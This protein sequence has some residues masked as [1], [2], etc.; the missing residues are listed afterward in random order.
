MSI[1]WQSMIKK[2]KSR[3][4]NYDDPLIYRKK[5]LVDENVSITKNGFPLPAVIEISESGMCN[6]KCVFCPRSDPHYE[7]VNEFIS[8]DLIERLTS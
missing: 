1:L 3:L 5:K 4:S 7:H 6:R 8:S 2:D